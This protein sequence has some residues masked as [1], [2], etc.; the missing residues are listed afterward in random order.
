MRVALAGKGGAGKTT[1]AA[2]LARVLARSGRRVVAIDADSSPN[3]GVALG[4]ERARASALAALPHTLVSRRIDGPALTVPV[5]DAVERYAARGP[6]GVQLLVMGAP[7]H[8]EEG[9]LCA[10]HATVSALLGDLGARPEIAV[11]VDLEAS[12][13]HLSRGTARHADML[14][15][16]A[17]PYYRALEAVRR[18]AVLA[19][20]LPIP[21]VTVVA[22]KVRSATDREAIGEFCERHELNLVAAVP[23]SD[24]ALDADRA[25]QPLLDHSPAAPAVSAV[26]DL[27]SLISAPVERVAPVGAREDDGSVPVSP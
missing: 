17:E 24:A 18:I 21:Q 20:E 13:E 7:G 10:A 25:G 27:A 11:V 8:A 23:W 15:L 1:I 22:N 4:L 12:P 19:A 3:L 14:L 5:E 2:T 16:V 6:D 26:A 9:C